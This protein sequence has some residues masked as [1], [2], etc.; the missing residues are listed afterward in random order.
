MTPTELAEILRRRALYWLAQREQSETELRRKLKQLIASLNRASAAAEAEA[1]AQAVSAALQLAETSTE[2]EDPK[3]GG[4]AP[5]MRQSASVSAGRSS[6]NRRVI[7]RPTSHSSRCSTEAEAEAAHQAPAPMGTGKPAL[8]AWVPAEVSAVLVAS[9]AASTALSRPPFRPS[10][11]ASAGGPGLGNL[12]VPDS[13]PHGSGHEPGLEPGSEAL[14]PAEHIDQLIAWLRERHYLS[15][16]RFVDSR[17]RVRQARFGMQRI[18]GELAQHGLS[19][20]EDD[21]H[22]LAQTELAR[23]HAVWLRKFGPTPPTDAPARAKQARFLGQR[24]FS[25]SVVRQVLRGDGASFEDSSG[26]AS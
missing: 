19:L 2:D 25:G 12:A 17:L 9:G 10:A 11:A 7:P 15:D 5:L 6:G 3:R 16:Q 4:D 18:Q 1:Q 22:Q 26:D 24:G 21:R 14:S 20:S 8:P 23:A 13:A